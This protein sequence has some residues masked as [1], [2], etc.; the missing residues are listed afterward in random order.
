ML[1]R[2]LSGTALLVAL[3][4]S[5][6]ALPFRG[7]GG[8]EAIIHA[9]KRCDGS[10]RLVAPD[11]ACRPNDEPVYWSVVGP[12]GPQGPVGPEGPAGPPGPQ[13]EE[14]T[15]GP[16]TCSPWR[17]IIAIDGNGLPTCALSVAGAVNAPGEV[18]NGAGFTAALAYIKVDLPSPGAFRSTALSQMWRKAMRRQRPQLTCELGE[19][20]AARVS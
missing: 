4:R 9:C 16:V 2:D 3:G 19:C 11:E 14:G 10:V 5:L 17:A 8:D 18:R 1:M 12:S 20:V 6:I 13:G 15:I 7:D